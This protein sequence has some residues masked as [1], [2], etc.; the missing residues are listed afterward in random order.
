MENKILSSIGL[1]LDIIGVILLFLYGLPSK[2]KEDDRGQIYLTVGNDEEAANRERNRFKRYRFL[3]RF[4]LALLII[5]FSLQIIA[6][7]IDPFCFSSLL[8]AA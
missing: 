8:R 2:V 6:N 5:G 7:H 1:L 4:A 3:S